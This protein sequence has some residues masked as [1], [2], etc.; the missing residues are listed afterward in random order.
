[1]LFVIHK[2]VV[3]NIQETLKHVKGSMVKL[4]SHS[5]IKCKTHCVKSIPGCAC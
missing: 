4:L 2:Y 3:T 5:I 1:M